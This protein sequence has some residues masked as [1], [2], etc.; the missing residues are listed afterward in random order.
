MRGRTRGS[1]QGDRMICFSDIVPASMTMSAA[2]IFS[3]RSS[4]G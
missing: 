3:C 1:K 4:A 2:N